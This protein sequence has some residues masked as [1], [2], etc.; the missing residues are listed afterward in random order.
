MNRLVS[1]IK[2]PIRVLAFFG[3]Y[4]LLVYCAVVGVDWWVGMYHPLGVTTAGEIR[5][6]ETALWDHFG[7]Y[8]AA[9]ILL[10]L[11]LVRRYAYP[12]TPQKAAYIAM[13]IVVMLC[14]GLVRERKHSKQPFPVA[15]QPIASAIPA[16]NRLTPQER[17]V[18][19]FPDLAIPNSK[20]NQEFEHRYKQYQSQNPAYFDNL[21][22]PTQ[23]A[24]ESQMALEKP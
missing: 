3:L 19:L 6:F 20:L 8:I 16:G 11:L 13:I 5:Q 12:K 4:A 17:A 1:L 10:P 22:W 18:Q 7:M 23:L 24:R 2:A 9:I 15:G 21:E 14:Y